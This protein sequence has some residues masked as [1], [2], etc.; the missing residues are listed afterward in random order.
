[1]LRQHENGKS[2]QRRRKERSKKARPLTVQVDRQQD[3][4]PDQ[5][6]N[7]GE[8]IEA[9]AVSIDVS[10]AELSVTDPTLPV[11]PAESAGASPIGFHTIAKAYSDYTSRSLEQTTSFFDRLAR[12]RSLVTA[13][14][15][16]IEFA[17]KAY[18][19]FT[20]DSQKIRE[21][22]NELARQR[23]RHLEGFMEKVT[24]TAL[25]RAAHP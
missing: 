9:P 24:Q 6:A 25:S 1:M 4:K 7:V 5:P 2:G 22:H 10:P 17:V 11:G 14:E 23:L 13:L 19:S 3:P 15:L 18:E 20:T 21:L 8:A 16:Q 12:E